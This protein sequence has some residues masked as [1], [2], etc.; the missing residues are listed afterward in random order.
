[1]KTA[2]S[3]AF[4]LLLGACHSEPAM[5]FGLHVRATTGDD[6]A[7]QTSDWCFPAGAHTGETIGTSIDRWEIG[8]PPPH[9]FMD[10]EPDAW[11]EV[12]R[13]RVY[14]ALE[15][16]ADGGWWQPSEILAERVYDAKFGE[17]GARDS[18]VVD[19]EGEPY[20]VEVQGLSATDTCP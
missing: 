16:E 3:F 7:E 14:V 2:T 6:P 20:T 12:Y 13:V 17:G 8:E 11:D 15:R 18:F 10:A 9:L 5:T 19:F 1:M 4:A